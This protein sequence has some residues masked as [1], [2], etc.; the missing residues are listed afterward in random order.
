MNGIKKIRSLVRL[1]F[2]VVDPG[3]VGF[4]CSR[5][6][7]SSRVVQRPGLGTNF[8]DGQVWLTPLF[9][10]GWMVGKPIRNCYT[11]STG[12]LLYVV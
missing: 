6:F 4:G 3:S 1:V 8:S 9:F 7:L 12:D 10:T 2:V 11:R 5:H